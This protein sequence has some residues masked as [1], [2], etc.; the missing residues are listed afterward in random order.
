MR[1][2]SGFTLL[3]LV[4]AMTVMGLVSAI[5]FPRMRGP[6]AGLQVRAARQSMSQM[7]VVARSAA[8]QSGSEARFIRNGNVTR[9][10]VDSSSVFVTLTA[11]DLATEHGVTLGVSA[12]G[13]DTLRF[14]PRG[15]AIGLNGAQWFRFTRDGTVDSV[16]VSRFGKVAQKGCS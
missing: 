6:I 1:P 10:V 13:R 8:I 9:V 7:I 11:K 15:V 16:C 4:L 12:G 3:D 5:A 14:D 2:R